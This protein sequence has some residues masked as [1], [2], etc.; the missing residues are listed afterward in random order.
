MKEIIITIL[1]IIAIFLGISM[2]ANFIGRATVYKDEE[3]AREMQVCL[4]KNVSFQ[5]CYQ[6]IYD[7]Y[8]FKVTK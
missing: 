4:E 6:A 3:K 5:D 1:I 2:F 8:A 7:S